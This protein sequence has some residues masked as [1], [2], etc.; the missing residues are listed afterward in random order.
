MKDSIRTHLTIDWH[1][2]VVTGIVEFSSE[3]GLRLVTLLAWE[4]QR[5]LRAFGAIPLSE[6]QVAGLTDA[7]RAEL[8]AAFATARR[9][10]EQAREAELVVAYQSMQEVLLRRPLP[11]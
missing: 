3:P 10:I 11:V 1:D 5:G 6:T 8:P 9:L 4:P 7:T 2:G